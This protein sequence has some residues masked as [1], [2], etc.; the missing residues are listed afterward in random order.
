M[1]R[2]RGKAAARGE[3][4][5]DRTRTDDRKRCVMIVEDDERVR[6]LI[7]ALLQ[8]EGFRAVELADGMEALNYLAFS[9][10]YHRDIP[11]PDLVVADIQMPNFSGL[12]LLMGMRESP[13]RPPV[14]LVTGIKDGEVHQE[15]RRLGAARVVTKPFDVDF[16]LNAVDDCLSRPPLP[17]VEPDVAIVTGAVADAE[18]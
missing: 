18:S 7:A 10:V 5:G 16:F 13:I 15:A 1:I 3:E 11:P 4:V 6:E 14:M 9:N 17:A 12:D 2:G 8:A